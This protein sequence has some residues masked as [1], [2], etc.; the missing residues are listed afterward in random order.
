MEVKEGI[1]LDREDAAQPGFG[2]DASPNLGIFKLSGWKALAALAIGVPLFLV[3]GV[4]IVA[5][6]IGG[7]LVLWILRPLLNLLLGPGPRNRRW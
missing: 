4:G 7:A 6:L 3:L 1:L 5:I 2:T